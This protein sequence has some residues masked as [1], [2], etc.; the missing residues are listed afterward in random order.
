MSKNPLFSSMGGNNSL[1]NFINAM[2]GAQDP[3]NLLPPH[4]AQ[5]IQNNQGKTLEQIVREE[6]ARRGVDINATIQQIF[7]KNNRG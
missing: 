1:S 3:M 6:Y 2:N 4:I 7:N 5:F